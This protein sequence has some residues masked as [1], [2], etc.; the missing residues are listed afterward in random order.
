MKLMFEL[1]FCIFFY[2]KHR[3]PLAVMC[4]SALAVD[5]K[6]VFIILRNVDLYLLVRFEI[7]IV[8][9]VIYQLFVKLK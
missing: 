4:S 5:R 7:V 8:C 3:H 6:K 9:Y 1:S 2:V